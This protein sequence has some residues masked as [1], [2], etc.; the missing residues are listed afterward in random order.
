MVCIST[1]ERAN[2]AQR[3]RDGI[4]KPNRKEGQRTQGR[5]LACEVA[6]VT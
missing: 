6:A 2:P 5:R 1:M 3:I 4:R